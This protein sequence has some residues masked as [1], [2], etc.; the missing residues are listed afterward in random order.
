MVLVSL[1][2][3]RSRRRHA[4]PLV[5]HADAPRALPRLPSMR[6]RSST[7]TRSTR[8]CSRRRGMPIRCMGTTHAD[9]FRGDIPVTRPMRHDE[10]ER[11][12]EKN[13]GLVIV[14]TFTP[15]VVARRGAGR[16]RRQ[17]RS[18][19]LG[20]GRVQGDRARARCSSTSPASN[21]A[22]AR[23][24]PTP[25]APRRLPRR[26]ALPAQA[27]PAG[28]LRAEMTGGPGPASEAPRA[29]LW[30]LDGTLVDSEEFHWLVVA[31]H[32][33]A[34]RGRADLRAVPRQLRTEER[35][36]PC[37]VAGR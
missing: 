25:P 6:R 22:S 31:R 28:V 16:A 35:S 10:V 14:E 5:R 24:L 23:W 2:T 19:H 32:D 26:Q 33:A 15:R 27:R 7:R 17:S 13:T 4:P 8:R 12:Y 30:D 36:H 11:D 18:V 34:G 20:R 37:R 21:G 1:E 3:G 9:Y 29:V